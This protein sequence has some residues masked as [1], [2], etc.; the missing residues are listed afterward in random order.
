MTARDLHDSSPLVPRVP[1]DR[2][3]DDLG[4]RFDGL[5][6]QMQQ[7][8]VREAVGRALHATAEEM[9]RAAVEG[10]R[11]AAT[12]ILMR[13][14]IRLPVEVQTADDLA[15]CFRRLAGLVHDDPDFAAAITTSA[16]GIERGIPPGQIASELET[17]AAGAPT[18]EASA[19]H[20]VAEALRRIAGPVDRR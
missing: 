7:P 20:G 9:A 17:Q 4:D 18:F 10:A 3:F 19:L 2:A 11:G 5:L 1:E 15:A 6:E 12:P 8:G 14:R 16:H 13:H